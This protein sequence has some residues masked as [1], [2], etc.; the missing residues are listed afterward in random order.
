MSNDSDKALQIAAKKIE[1]LV[2]AEKNAFVKRVVGEIKEN[3]L[4]SHFLIRSVEVLF[5]YD[6]HDLLEEFNKTGIQSLKD[7]TG[8]IPEIKRENIERAKQHEKQLNFHIFYWGILA[9]YGFTEPKHFASV[10]QAYQDN[11]GEHSPVGKSEAWAEKGVGELEL[12]LADLAQDKGGDS[13]KR[14]H[15]AIQRSDDLHCNLGFLTRKALYRTLMNCKLLTECYCGS[16]KTFLQKELSS[17][18]GREATW[19]DLHAS[20]PEDW[21]KITP[22]P[23]KKTKPGQKL[24]GV[25]ENVFFYILRDID[26]ENGLGISKHGYV[27][28]DSQNLAY[29]KAHNLWALDTTLFGITNKRARLILE[30]INAEIKHNNPKWPYTISHL[31]AAIY[32]PDKPLIEDR[33]WE[34]FVWQPGDIEI[35]KPSE[36]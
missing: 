26:Y 21:E 22:K 11:K 32:Q 7:K 6:W 34:R 12:F 14:L 8:L 18:L 5:S 35:I 3:T 10:L 4:D 30:K 23:W 33:A 9:D 15:E 36:N 16:Y 31:N 2:A 25:G 29:F 27:K 1:Y 24:C 20:K 28:L 19:L 13:G 17:V